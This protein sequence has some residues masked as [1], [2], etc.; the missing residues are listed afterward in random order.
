[1]PPKANPLKLNA[2]Q[3]RTLALLQVIAA[4]PRLAKLDD[5]TGD[6]T[7]Y[8]LPHAHGDHMH[9]GSFVVSARDASG[10]FNPSVWAALERKGLVRRGDPGPST[11]TREAI[12]YNTGFGDRFLEQSDH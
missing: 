10:L 2:L 7:I 6:A 12:A 9:V 3:L 1:M 5:E 8:H 11:V 4:D